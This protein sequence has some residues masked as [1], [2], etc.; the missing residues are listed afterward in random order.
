MKPNKTF[1]KERKFFERESSFRRK[2]KYP[3]SN[4]NKDFDKTKNKIF[5]CHSPGT[6]EGSKGRR[7][8]EARRDPGLRA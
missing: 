1:V 6:R 7:E 3:P 5:G 8:V 4:Q 2:F